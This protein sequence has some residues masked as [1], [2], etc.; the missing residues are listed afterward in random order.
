MVG[1]N[2]VCEM[3]VGREVRKKGKKCWAGDHKKTPGVVQGS[4]CEF[5]GPHGGEGEA[6]SREGGSSGDVLHQ[7]RKNT[8]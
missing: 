2:W 5:A 8:K 3:R 6:E 4:G 7:N 1:V